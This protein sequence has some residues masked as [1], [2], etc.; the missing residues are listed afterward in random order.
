MFH[1]QPIRNEGG[2]KHL[3]NYY[4]YAENKKMLY[5]CESYDELGL[6]ENAEKHH[7][8]SGNACTKMFWD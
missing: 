3:K 6:P 8:W 4:L 7:S 2:E 1:L 5:L